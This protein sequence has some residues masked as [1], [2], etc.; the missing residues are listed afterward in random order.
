MLVWTSGM[1]P[2]FALV[3]FIVGLMFVLHTFANAF[4][5]T[6]G[7]DREDD[8]K[9]NRSHQGCDLS[10]VDQAAWACPHPKC[11]A[12]N[13]GH[14]RYCRMCGRSRVQAQNAGRTM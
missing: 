2:A 4:R 8:L 5:W 14:A 3:F 9:S 1:H 10:H 7:W 6:C 13:P 12:Q 11:L